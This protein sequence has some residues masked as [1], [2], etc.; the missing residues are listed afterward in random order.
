MRI[1]AIDRYLEAKAAI[2]YIKTPFLESLFYFMVCCRPLVLGRFSAILASSVY[3]E[4][5]GGTKPRRNRTETAKN[6]KKTP[7]IKTRGQ[8]KE[9]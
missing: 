7:K 9:F 2:K 5:N 8:G 6:T 1:L 3:R 4:N